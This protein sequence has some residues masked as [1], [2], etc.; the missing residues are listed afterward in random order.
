MA[1]LVCFQITSDI[2]R[3]VFLQGFLIDVT[4][5]CYVVRALA[6]YG[7]TEWNVICASG[8]NLLLHCGA[9]RTSSQRRK[10]SV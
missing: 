10:C 7:S 1:E 5:S 4:T 3:L 8:P 2:A 6:V 9:V